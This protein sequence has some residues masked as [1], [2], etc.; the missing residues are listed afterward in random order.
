MIRRYRVFRAWRAFP[1]TVSLLTLSLPQTGA[2]QAIADFQRDPVRLV[3]ALG[4]GGDDKKSDRGLAFDLAL[5]GEHA[6]GADRWS[7]LKPEEK[8][9]VSRAFDQ[10]VDEQLEDWVDDSSGSTAVLH[11]QISGAKATV[12]TLRGA[13]LLR[14][15]LVSRNNAWYVVEIEES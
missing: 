6:F 2:Q 11:H 13:D 5:A 14:V 8:A 10:A 12:L 7:K 1:L 4:E 9:S 15:S 3:L